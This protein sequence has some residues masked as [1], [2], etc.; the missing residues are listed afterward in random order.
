MHRILSL[1]FG[2][3][4][5][6]F[7]CLLLSVSAFANIAGAQARWKLTET[8]R[9]GGAESGPEAFIYTK[10]IEVDAKGRIFVYDRKTQDIRLFG[11][12]GK[13]VKVIG[14]LGSGPGELR[15]AEGLAIARD[16]KLWVRDAA[17]AR[18][19]VFSSEGVFEKGWTMK[20]CS[21]QGAWNPQMDRTG[22]IVDEDCIVGGGRAFKF[23][24]L[25]Y[26]TDMSRVDTLADKPACG[27]TELNEAGTWITRTARGGSYRSIPYAASSHT[28]IGPEGEVWC[29]PNSSNYEVLRLKAGA[30]DTTRIARSVP[31][32]PVT[33]FERDSVIA[34]I[35]SRAPTGL[36][37]SR[38]PKVK[39]A[40]DRLTVDDQGRLWV[41]HTNAK[42]AIEFDIY[43]ANGRIIA[44][45][46]LGV[47]NS[48]VWQPFV[49]HGDN[50]YAVV[51]DEDDVQH[52]A[53]FRITR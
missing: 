38:I 51:L 3:A 36:D 22:R 33:P 49:V 48:S 1:R 27:S 42:G 28:A 21:S 31:V 15:D 16:G 17:N 52:V 30:K 53:R 26:H 23:A 29:V 12:D 18:F 41:R 37:F 11:P 35:E 24:V 2:W 46:E 39:P 20:F 43:S 50:V 19:S 10:S 47:Y 32:V 9:I 7:A 40:I 14:R 5:G 4:L 8:L 6:I 45:A 13:L 44:S 34:L 25:A